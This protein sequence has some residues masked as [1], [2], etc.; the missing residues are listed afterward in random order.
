[1]KKA[2]LA[3]RIFGI[4]LVCLLFGGISCG[5]TDY[6]GND[7]DGNKISDTP[8]GIYPN[9]NNYPLGEPFE[10][11]VI[12]NGLA[13]SPWPKFRQNLQ[14]TGRSPYTGPAIPE[15]KWTS[16]GGTSSPAIGT[17]GTVYTGSGAKLYAINSDG[18]VKWSFST[19]GEVY[20]SPA[21]AADDTIY[22]GSHDYNLYAIDPTGTEKWRFATGSYVDSSP[23]IGVDGT[24]YVGSRDGNLYAIDSEGSKKWNIYL[25]QHIMRS[26]PAIGTDNTIYVGTVSDYADDWKLHAINPDGTIKW[27]LYVN[28]RAYSSPAIAADGTIYIGTGAVYSLGGSNG[29]CAI[30]PAGTLKWS[31]ATENAVE[32]SAAI[33]ADG[34]IYVGSVDTYV[35]ALNPNGTKKWSFATGSWVQSSPAVGADG[36]IYV[37]SLDGKLYA[38]NPE[39]TEKWSFDTGHWIFSSPAIAADGTIYVGSFDGKLYA[40]GEGAP[41]HVSNVSPEND[42]TDVPIDTAVTATFSEPMDSSTITTESF[43]LAGSTVSG[44]VTYDPDSYTATFTPDANLEYDHQYTATLST[45]ITDSAGNPL[46]E[47]YIWSFA[48]STLAQCKPEVSITPGTPT[49]QQAHTGT[50]LKYFVTVANRGYETDTMEIEAQGDPALEWLIMLVPSWDGEYPSTPVDNNKFQV[51]LPPGESTDYYVYVDIGTGA[52]SIDVSAKSIESPCEPVNCT[53]KAWSLTPGSGLFAAILLFENPNEEGDTLIFNVPSNAMISSRYISL[54]PSEQEWIRVMYDPKSVDEA[55]DTWVEVYSMH[56]GNEITIPIEFGPYYEVAAT[57]FDMAQDSYNFPNPLGQF[58]YGMSETSILY[59]QEELSLPSNKSNTYSLTELEAMRNIFWHQRFFERSFL[60]AMKLRLLNVDLVEEYNKLRTNIRNGKPMILAVQGHTVVA[61]RIFETGSKSYIYIYENELPYSLPEDDEWSDNFFFAFPYATYDLI[62]HEFDYAGYNEFLALEAETFPM[63]DLPVVII[64]ECSVDVTVSD[65]FDRI[66]DNLGIN[67]I[68]EAGFIAFG[69]EKHF[70]LPKDLTY[71][72]YIDA[73]EE[74]EFDL[75]VMSPVRQDGAVITHFRNVSVNATTQANFELE[76]TVHSY[77]M[78]IDY[79][80]DGIIDEQKSPDVYEILGP[81]SSDPV[82]FIATAAYGTPMAQE[83]EIL[84]EFRDEYLLTNPLG[85][86]LV[87]FYYEVSPPIAEF[88]IEHPSLK[89]MVRVGLL[90]AV[91]MSTVIVNTT[92]VEKIAI[93]VLLMLIS[94]AVAVWVIR[95]RGRGSEYTQG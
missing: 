8:Y 32:S 20:S 65:Q 82:C 39:G 95:R 27:S 2:K 85:R 63:E 28:G 47:P 26:S 56:S 58:C 66:M 68:P 55:Y 6:V 10:N 41:V 73:Y 69:E 50:R 80:G 94:V 83:I 40:I 1:M 36:T 70:F 17:D 60:G 22:V 24:I 71:C 76:P 81:E 5:L 25:G 79:N 19:G 16:S 67:E 15:L 9:N 59:F 90:P 64:I 92:P 38:I 93:L 12:G 46:A 62:S 74:G 87:D 51:V 23:S 30:N 61:Y 29:L 52:N 78:E 4:V 45:A 31:F 13:D 57:G 72:V 53:L 14:N 75:T 21:I 33:G 91:A 18:T 49:F 42:A 48:T 86:A 37:G 43:T 84:R 7:V 11:D 44:I 77:A 3:G 35:Y 54:G 34:T 89:P 88:I